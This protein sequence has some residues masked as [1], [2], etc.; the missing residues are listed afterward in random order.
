MKFPAPPQISQRR[1]VVTG[2]GMVTPLGNSTSATWKA[3]LEGRTGVRK[4]RDFPFY[5]RHHPNTVDLPATTCAFVKDPRDSPTAFE[6]SKLVPRYMR[7]ADYACDEA[8][9]DAGL[10]G[11]SRNKG[12]TLLE[13]VNTERIAVCVGTGIGSLPDVGEATRQIDLGQFKRISPY[14][15]PRILVNMAG[16]NIG[17][18]YKMLG[19]I[20]SAVTACATSAHTVGDAF[21]FIKYNDADIAVCGGTEAAI[22][23]VA[24]AGFSRAK[25]LA[26]DDK[27]EPHQISRPFDSKRCGFVM[28]EGAAILILEEMQ[29]AVARN[30]KIYAEIRGY[31]L[32]GDGHHITA[33][34]PDGRGAA[35]AMRRALCE[36]GLSPNDVD[37]VNAHATSTP[38]GDEI[39]LRAIERVFCA[40]TKRAQPLKVSST[41]GATGHLLGAAGAVEAAFVCLGLRDGVVPATLNLHDPSPAPSSCVDLLAAEAVPDSEQEAPGSFKA[42]REA[43]EMTAAVTNSFGFGNT[44]ASLAFAQFS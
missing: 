23:P 42:A 18:K 7:F 44:N 29:H 25:A 22:V 24:I 26:C 14:F 40:E 43:K 16:G 38:L 41:K 30:A 11:T 15:V 27:L 3:L 1:V 6:E 17:I 28:G 2:V 31:G 21:R 36:A 5:W 39:E 37:Y 10:L 13:S 19:P 34:H 35:L 12:P 9:K 33:P 20:H 8:L 4:L 32:S